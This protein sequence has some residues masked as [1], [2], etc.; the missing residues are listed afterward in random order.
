MLIISEI[1]QWLV[2]I[3]DLV[4]L[5]IIRLV[6]LQSWYMSWYKIGISTNYVFNDIFD[7]VIWMDD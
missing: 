7:V 6:H 1:K 3:L 4:Y 2:L 5:Q